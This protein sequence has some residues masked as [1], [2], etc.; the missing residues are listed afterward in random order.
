MNFKDRVKQLF[1][2]QG[3][4]I[5]THG[6][7]NFLVQDSNTTLDLLALS[8]P[9]QEQILQHEPHTDADRTIIFLPHDLDEQQQDR[10]EQAARKKGFETSYLGQEEEH[11]IDT[12]DAMPSSY[13]IIG[14]IAILN[15]DDKQMEQAEKIAR[16]VKKQ[17]PNIQTV[18]NKQDSLSGEYRVGDY[19]TILG[20]ET[21][22]IHIEHGCRYRV[23]PT[24]VYFSERLGHERERILQQIQQAETI[25]VWFAGVGPYAILFARK[26][27]PEQV[28]AI[29]KNPQAC[30]YLQ[31]NIE[32]NSVED[33]VT[34]HCGDV[35]EIAPDLGT[36]DRI[37]MPLP[38]SADDFLDLALQHI[39]TDGVI[40]YYRFCSEDD[41]WE[42]PLQEIREAADR[43][44]RQVEIET[45]EVCGHYAPYIDRVCIDI[46]VTR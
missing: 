41:Q 45:K 33:T 14:D 2:Q 46:R 4:N 31:E 44:G 39:N 12:P 36:A 43:Q 30:E 34:A 25:Q 19:K 16:A 8:N 26:A 13:E 10:V 15:L 11:D 18:L 24:Q 28:H 7:T 3:F 23:D 17:N 9:T 5:K 21:E 1:K 29:E 35:R 6:E 20:S 22:T 40:H 37:V 42:Q 38:G 32:L 27:S